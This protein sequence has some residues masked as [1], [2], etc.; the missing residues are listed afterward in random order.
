[1]WGIPMLALII[2]T[3]IYL[4]VRTH[5]FQIIYAKFVSNTTFLGIFKNR[6]VTTSTDKKAISQFQAL[7]TAL[8]ATIGVGN[9]A[10]VATAISIGGAGAV[11]WMWLSAFFGMMTNY[12]ENVLGIYF[13]KRNSKNEWS[14]GAMYYI[15][16]G[17][18]DRKFLRHLG[19]PLA[20][21]F[22]IFCVLASFGIG[23][24]A[25]IVA[26]FMNDSKLS[27]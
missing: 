13:R 15:E 4:T 2:G 9:I 19:R 16:N 7:S 17:F 23:N 21:L 5:F 3:G 6:A 25:D 22:S 20:V 18:K 12:S 1:V 10:G 24:I 11:F 14:G 8:A 27:L 26:Y